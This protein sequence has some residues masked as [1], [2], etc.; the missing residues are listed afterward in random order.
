MIAAHPDDIDFASGGSVARWVSEGDTV[1]YCICTDGDAGGYDESVGRVEMAELRHK[2]Q[3][4]AAD[5]YGVSEIDWLGHP[6]GRLYVTHELRRDIS[7]SIRKHR[8]D[9]VVIPSPTRQL[10]NLYGS[11]PDHIAA[12]EAAMCAVYPDARNPF[13]HPELLAEEGLEAWTVPETWISSPGEGADTY[14]DITDFIDAKVR[15]LKAHVSQTAHMA[16]LAE[17]MQMWGYAQAKA[18]GWCEDGTPED[19]RRFAEG[20]IV[21]DTK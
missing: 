5:V 1:D 9:R 12:G 8:P 6:D 17:R 20:F 13:A 2:E 10:R 16:D 15:A 18:A 19:E 11:H 14:V 7:R 3:R 4:D 21:L